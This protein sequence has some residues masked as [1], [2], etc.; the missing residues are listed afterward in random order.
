MVGM[1]LE[2]SL[3]FANT[4]SWHAG[5]SPEERLVDYD[6][7]LE[8]ARKAG[9]LNG[10]EAGRLR[11]Q[12]DADPD[13]RAEAMRRIIALREA[14]YRI[15]SA[16][17]HGRPP[18]SSDL[19]LLNTE[20]TLAHAH[21]RLAPSA[22]AARGHEGPPGHPG[23]QQFAWEWAGVNDDLTSL[24]WPV[25]RSATMLLTS[26]EL[27]RV[28]ECADDCCGWLLLDRSRNASRRWCDMSDCGNRAKARRYRERNKRGASPASP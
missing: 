24:L 14:I 20:L 21:L 18:D 16:V 13:G 27:V 11:A 26:P 22:E 10:G 1:T 23:L 2:L 12:A 17:A 8:W 19:Q 4:V 7:A 3:E 15:F 6:K 28:R 25:A 9:I 5:P